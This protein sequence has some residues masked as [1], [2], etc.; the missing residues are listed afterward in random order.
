MSNM[1]KTLP[2][3][4]EIISFS[5]SR[6]EHNQRIICAKTFNCKNYAVAGWIETFKYLFEISST[7]LRY[8]SNKYSEWYYS[9]KCMKIEK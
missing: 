5:F 9:Y 6:K 1:C 2:C 3:A 8:Y 4:V 7:T